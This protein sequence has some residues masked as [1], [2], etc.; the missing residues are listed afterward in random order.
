M[1][2]FVCL[3]DVQESLSWC[4]YSFFIIFIMHALPYIRRRRRRRR[5]V[6]RCCKPNTQ[7]T[8]IFESEREPHVNYRNGLKWSSSYSTV[9]CWQTKDGPSTHTTH[10]R[11]TVSL[12]HDSARHIECIAKLRF[13]WK[14]EKTTPFSIVRKRTQIDLLLSRVSLQRSWGKIN[15]APL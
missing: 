15:Q 11:M 8:H 10:A 3:R 9:L 13:D 12:V 2:G 5:L 1:W 6:R 7:D 4:A 14:I